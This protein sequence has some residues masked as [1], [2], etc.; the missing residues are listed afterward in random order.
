METQRARSGSARVEAKQSNYEYDVTQSTARD[1]DG[2]SATQK[3][4]L[5]RENHSPKKGG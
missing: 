3:G 5:E 1:H 4:N 2:G